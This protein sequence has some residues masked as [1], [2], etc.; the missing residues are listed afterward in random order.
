MPLEELILVPED[1]QHYAAYGAVIYALEDLGRTRPY[2]GVRQFQASVE[3]ARARRVCA[4]SG[5]PLVAT[6]E[7]Q[8]RFLRQYAPPR[9]R[10]AGFSPG[11]TVR[12]VIGLDGGSTSSL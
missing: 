1:A 10:P 8:E 7:Q 6:A 4:D 3:E 11:Q 5:P 9:F 12:A 2:P